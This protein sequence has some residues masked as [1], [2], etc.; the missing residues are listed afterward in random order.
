[1]N[2]GLVLLFNV[3]ELSVEELFV[4]NFVFVFFRIELG[5]LH[6]IRTFSNALLFDLAQD[7]NN[8]NSLRIC[9]MPLRFAS[10]VYF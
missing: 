2:I 7:V 5:A 9:F 4:E 6:G 3:F 10:V 1:L 8:K